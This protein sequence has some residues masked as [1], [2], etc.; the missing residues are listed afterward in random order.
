VWLENPGES[1]DVVLFMELLSFQEAK[2]KLIIP[3]RIITP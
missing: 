1:M 2:N 3:K